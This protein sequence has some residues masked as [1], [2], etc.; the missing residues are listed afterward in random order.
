MGN[1]GADSSSAHV[2]GVGLQRSDL[3]GRRRDEWS[4]SSTRPIE[5]QSTTMLPVICVGWT[6]QRKKDV[7]IE[8]GD[9][10]RARCG[11]WEDLPNE[12]PR[13]RGAVGVDGH[14]VRGVHIAVRELN[15]ERLPHGGSSVSR[16]KAIPC[17]AI[18]KVSSGFC[19]VPSWSALV[20][21]VTIPSPPATNAT[22]ATRPKSE[23]RSAARTRPR[24]DERG[25]RQHG[26]A[27]KDSDDW[28][29]R[30]WQTEED[31]GEREAQEGPS[32]QAS[33]RNRD[34]K[35]QALARPP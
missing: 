15:R 16:S 30:L 21:P 5:V 2:R 11:P 34:G 10:V 35:E 18:I 20:L 13:R 17:A 23:T 3:P 33:Q 4:W 28:R 22:P 1:K 26:C 9:A 7:R 12:Q 24:G 25:N 14:I 27:N 32:D 6:S 19:P 8:R 29:C 31:A